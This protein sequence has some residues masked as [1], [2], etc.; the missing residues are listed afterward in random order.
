MLSYR[1]CEGVPGVHMSGSQKANSPCETIRSASKPC[2]ISSGVCSESFTSCSNLILQCGRQATQCIVQR[3]V[4][5]VCRHSAAAL[6]VMRMLHIVMAD[7]TSR[8]RVL[9][10]VHPKLQSE[11]SQPT[12]WPTYLITGS[13]MLL[14]FHVGIFPCHRPAHR[15]AQP[16]PW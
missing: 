8:R 3:T 11:C 14:L 6:H 4:S 15:S 9:Y 2:C 12:D 1:A 13:R 5:Y 16:R 7:M 10:V